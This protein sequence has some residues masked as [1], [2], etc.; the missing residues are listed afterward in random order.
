MLRGFW[1]Q[2]R[3]RVAGG[4]RDERVQ[5]GIVAETEGNPLALLELPR[6][7]T[8]AELGGGFGVLDTRGLPGR[9]EESFVR[10]LEALP[11]DTQQLLLIA[12]AE[13]VGEPVLMWRGGAAP[14][15]GRPA[16]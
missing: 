7:L 1:G 16:G 2:L 3:G 12:A 14:V 11:T 5:D 6:A 13:P 9:I 15:G 4:R 10:R 8:F